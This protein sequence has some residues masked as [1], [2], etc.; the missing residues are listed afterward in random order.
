MMLCL[1]QYY[2]IMK[3]NVYFTWYALCPKC[4]RLCKFHNAG[5]GICWDCRTVI[6]NNYL[7]PDENKALQSAMETESNLE[8]T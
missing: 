5:K 3:R 1:N 2:T 4:Q 8:M 6:T 7:S